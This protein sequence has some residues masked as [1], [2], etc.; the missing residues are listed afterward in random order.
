MHNHAREIN[1]YKVTSIV[2]KRDKPTPSKLLFL[3]L[4]YLHLMYTRIKVTG[5][6]LYA[7]LRMYV[8]V[9]V[10]IVTYQHID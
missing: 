2:V 4:P 3:E 5:H 1:L 10:H 8:R 6:V 9:D 7:Q